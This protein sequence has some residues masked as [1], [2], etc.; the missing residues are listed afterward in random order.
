MLLERMASIKRAMRNAK[1][2]I[3]LAFI[4]PDETR[5]IPDSAQ[6]LRAV[7]LNCRDGGWGYGPRCA[8][9][10]STGRNVSVLQRQLPSLA[11]W[12]V[13]DFSTARR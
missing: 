10:Y 5:G 12:K 3:C 8:V 7:S 4:P 9:P 2:K 13:N 11:F 6:H 1:E